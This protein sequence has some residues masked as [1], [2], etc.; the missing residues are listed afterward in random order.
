[1]LGAI[2]SPSSTSE[3]G[4]TTYLEYQL[5]SDWIFT[6]RYFVRLTN[7]EVDASAGWATSIWGTD[8]GAAKRL[9]LF[10]AVAQH[11]FH[12]FLGFGIGHPALVFFHSTGAG[13]VGCQGKLEV[14][15][16]TIQHLPEIA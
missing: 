12:V 9:C 16:E 8:T 13:V 6:D 1:M 3:M 15:A 5:C 11:A 2:G 14:A 10:T 4:D 7:D